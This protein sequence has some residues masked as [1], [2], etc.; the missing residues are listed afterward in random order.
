MCNNRKGRSAE[1]AS[2]GN[3]RGRRPHCRPAAEPEPASRPTIPTRP[4]ADMTSNRPT[5]AGRHVLGAVLVCLLAGLVLRDGSRRQRPGP[6]DQAIL[7]FLARS[8]EDRVEVLDLGPSDTAG[9]AAALCDRAKRRGLCLT[10]LQEGLAADVRNGLEVPAAVRVRY[11][12]GGKERDELF[13]VLEGGII[14]ARAAN[15]D[16]GDWLDRL[17]AREIG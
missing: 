16:G 13:A 10:P 15:P 12:A 3:Y 7:R 1:K 4:G 6:A 2:C 5:L 9:E 17:R 8:A 11:R 14:S